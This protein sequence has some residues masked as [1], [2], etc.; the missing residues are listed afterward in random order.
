MRQGFFLLDLETIFFETDLL[1]FFLSTATVVPSF[2]FAHRDQPSND[3]I[4]LWRRRLSE[5]PATDSPSTPALDVST[6][7][8]EA[9][10]E[11]DNVEESPATDCNLRSRL[12]ADRRRS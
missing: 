12:L 8:D 10:S 9:P 6:T 2:F 11:H 4:L 5:D 1:D 3:P 7:D